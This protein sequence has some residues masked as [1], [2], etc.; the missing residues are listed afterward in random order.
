MLELDDESSG[1]V[2]VI[3]KNR[4][5]IKRVEERVDEACHSCI[6]NI[7][8]MDNK[9]YV[10]FHSDNFRIQE[11]DGGL[12]KIKFYPNTYNS[13]GPVISSCGE[14]LDTAVLMLISSV[15]SADESLLKVLEARM[16][17][18]K[19]RDGFHD[20]LTQ[21]NTQNVNESTDELNELQEETEE[22][23][24]PHK[25]DVQYDSDKADADLDFETRMYQLS[26]KNDG[27][28]GY[29]A[30]VVNYVYK[31]ET[32]DV[33]LLIELPDQSRGRVVYD[34]PESKD[35]PLVDVL[36]SA[37]ANVRSGN[38][39]VSLENIESIVGAR[40]PVFST[41]LDDGDITWSIDVRR[42]IHPKDV[43]FY[44][45]EDESQKNN[46]SSVSQYINKI[47]ASVVLLVLLWTT[48]FVLLVS[49]IAQ[50]GWAGI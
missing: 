33:A 26:K 32:E 2:T 16:M 36:D 44:A 39:S 11:T 3:Q 38:W 6:R 49:T 50:N 22:E 28:D 18:I 4:F 31:D 30:R 5:D 27:G 12:V 35:S 47:A 20:T 13:S 10:L 25:I 37:F 43:E 15:A 1:S 21:V 40:I 45:G 48:V 17:D 7:M 46:T 19:H 23:S 8:Y 29:I 14:D 34:V 42:N 41:E 24:T 9:R